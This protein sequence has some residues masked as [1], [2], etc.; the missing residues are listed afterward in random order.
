[1]S[2]TTVVHTAYQTA[3][4][5]SGATKLWVRVDTEVDILARCMWLLERGRW[6]EA[7][8]L[9]SLHFSKPH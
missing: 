1:M 8:N 3:D 5:V 7:N 9:Y 6:E 4:F 2:Q